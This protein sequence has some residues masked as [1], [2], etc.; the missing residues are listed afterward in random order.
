MSTIL[1]KT[2]TII[3]DAPVYTDSKKARKFP[4]TKED[5]RIITCLEALKKELDFL[6]NEFDQATNSIL[7]DSITYE[8]QAVHLRYMY[9][10]GL[11]KE[12][13]IVREEF[14]KLR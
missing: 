8:I 14:T 1:T 13:A 2:E 12:K 9:Y 5:R 7:I 6:H 4:L 10:L 3:T 11:C